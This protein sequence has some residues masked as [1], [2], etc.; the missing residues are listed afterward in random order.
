MAPRVLIAD[1]LSDQAIE[2]LRGY[3]LQVDAQSNVAQRDLA[4]AVA[5]AAGLV[6]RSRVSVDAEVIDAG[7]EL[8]VIG[9]AGIGVDNID[10]EAATRRGIIVMN[11]PTGNVTSAAEHTLALILAEARN[12]VRAHGALAAGRWERAAFTGIELE[13]KVLG[14]VG[15][16]KIGARVARYARALGMEVVA[17]DPHVTRERAEQIGARLVPLDELLRVADVVTVHTTLNESTRHLID[18]AALRLMK[19]T[20]RLVNVARGGIVDEAALAEAL[21][22]G[23]LA[24][25]ALDVYEQEPPPPG[26]PLLGQP[27]ATLTPH[28]G[29]S[30]EE[31]RLKVAA[32]IARQIG[33]FFKTGIAQNAVNVPAL[34]DPEL[35]P[36]LRLGEDLGSLCRQLLEGRVETIEVSYH[37]ELAKGET[38]AITPAVL[39]GFLDPLYGK[40]ITIVNAAHKVQERGIR[41][42]ETRRVVHKGFT[43]LLGVTLVSDAGTRRVAGTVLEDR[44][45][46]VV[47]IDDYGIDLQP[48]KHMLLTF[49]PDRPGMVG[50]IGTILGDRKINIARM[51][52]GRL[53]RGKQAVMVMTVDDPVPEEVLRQIRGATQIDEVRAVTLPG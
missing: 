16:G 33:E 7:K 24:G 14:I 51:E 30:T 29:A 35:V 34:P 18:A 12:V 28:L 27:R 40:S 23:R 19:P 4:A 25:A 42:V 43:S 22:E 44:G 11:T 45:P 47:M 36:Y 52:V 31:A 3:G 15:L 49:Y 17:F 46:R 41:V 9:R 1:D 8:R 5:G 10:V 48:S 20:A 50:K 21:R 38:A 37:G 39:K 32:D 6:V 2:V 53:G 13:G 26:H